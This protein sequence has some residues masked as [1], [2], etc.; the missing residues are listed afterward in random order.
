M[1]TPSFSNMTLKLNIFNMQRQP[2]D[3]DDVR[4]SILHWVEDS[5]FDYD[6]DDMLAAEYEFFVIDKDHEYDMFEFDDLCSVTDCLLASASESI[7]EFVFPLA[8]L[9]LNPYM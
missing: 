1:V 9:E 8:A 5:V 4:F 7:S 6:L 2:F 3:F